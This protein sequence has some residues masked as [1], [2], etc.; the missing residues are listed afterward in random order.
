MKKETAIKRL[1]ALTTKKGE[2]KK[3]YIYPILEL[4]RYPKARHQ[5]MYW[6]GKGSSLQDLSD[7]FLDVLSALK[8][9]YTY[10]NDAPRYG[11]EGW[12]VKLTKSGI[13]AIKE[14]AEYVTS[15]DTYENSDRLG[16]LLLR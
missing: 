9:Q 10:T 6:R 12:N 14:Y 2:L 1:S 11:L 16:E 4:C 3:T 7:R 5:L 8:V 15:I 13:K